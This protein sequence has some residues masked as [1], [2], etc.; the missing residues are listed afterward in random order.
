MFSRNLCEKSVREKLQFHTVLPHC[1]FT[2]FLYHEFL[3]NFRENN[4]FS[5]EFTL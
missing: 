4:F 5:I 3:K 1:G 2:K